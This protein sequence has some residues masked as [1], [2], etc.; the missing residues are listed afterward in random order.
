MKIRSLLRVG[1]GQGEFLSVLKE[2][3]VEG[4]GIEHKE[5]L[6]KLARN[7][8]LNVEQGFMEDEKTKI[9]GAPFDVFFY[10]LTSLNISLIRMKCF[11]NI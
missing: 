2:F 8:G 10:L 11:R 4:F 7:K 1:C 5:D 9:V 6:V 3:P